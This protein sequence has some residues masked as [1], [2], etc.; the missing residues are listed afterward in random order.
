MGAAAPEA[1]EAEEEETGKGWRVAMGE[2]TMAEGPMVARRAACLVEE[3][4]VGGTIRHAA[5]RE[6]RQRGLRG[7]RGR[8]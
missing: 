8:W 6:T 7:S 1:V 2:V 5:R 3:M 4:R